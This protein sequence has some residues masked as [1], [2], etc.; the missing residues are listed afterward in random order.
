MPTSPPRFSSTPRSGPPPGSALS[1]TA[2]PFTPPPPPSAA[3]S[4]QPPSARLGP[5]GKPASSGSIWSP[6]RPGT[7]EIPRALLPPPPP[8]PPS[9]AQ[10]PNFILASPGQHESAHAGAEEMKERHRTGRNPRTSRKTPKSGEA[11]YIYTGHGTFPP[12]S[13]TRPTPTP[14]PPPP[15]PQ[16]SSRK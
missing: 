13:H 5:D 8:P 12:P 4:S 10:K 1:P 9:A 6:P 3:A 15:P 16:H 2:T 14:T 7:T 11:G